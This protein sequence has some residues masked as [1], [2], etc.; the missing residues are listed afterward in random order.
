MESEKKKSLNS[1]IYAL[2][3]SENIKHESQRQPCNNIA[4]VLLSR[5]KVDYLK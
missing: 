2:L 4:Q 1:N 5:E 3:V